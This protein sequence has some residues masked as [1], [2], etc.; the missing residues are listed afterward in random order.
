MSYHPV[1]G[2]SRA[3]SLSEGSVSDSATLAPTIA[4][5]AS[6]LVPHR[7]RG[8][9]SGHSPG[10]HTIKE[11]EDADADADALHAAPAA[12]GRD[13]G[14]RE[15]LAWA[16][17]VLATCVLLLE[18]LGA[19]LAWPSILAARFP[20]DVGRYN[21]GRIMAFTSLGWYALY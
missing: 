15:L 18:P 14:L 6:T 17:L 21:D 8:A 7:E 5:S 13:A 1:P 9:G 4:S 20:S 16:S 11:K 2:S 12:L 19:A 3:A 10:L